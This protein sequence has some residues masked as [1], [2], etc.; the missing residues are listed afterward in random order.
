M[1]DP[2]PALPRS[3][4]IVYG[5]DMSA[6]AL[7]SDF[8]HTLAAH[9][10]RVG[11]VVQRNT[12]VEAGCAARME[13]E[14]VATGRVILIS[15]SLGAGSAACRLDPQGLAEAAMVLRR[16]VDDRV[17]LLVVNKFSGQEAAGGGL[18]D[19]MLLALAEGVPLLTA[20]A[21]RHLDRWQTFT[22]GCADLL[23]PDPA[24]LRNWWA[25]L[26]SPARTVP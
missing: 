10:V 15:Q 26:S 20:V 3:G 1:T 5:P 8:A 14:D 9:G 17:D 25:G 6:D 4:A 16:A 11:G 23:A 12:R 21:T 19:E 24:A 2:D 7:L 22:G 18:A 13:L